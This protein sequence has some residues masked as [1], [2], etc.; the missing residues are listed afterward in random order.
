MN[1]TASAETLNLRAIG[2]AARQFEEYTLT[3]TA[4]PGVFW[5]KR[6]G[7]AY[8]TSLTHCSCEQ[9]RYRCSQVSGSECK[10]QSL[11]RIR[12]GAPSPFASG[13]W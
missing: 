5:V 11:V 1:S 13:L 2:R 10:H 4:Q 8:V 6:D 7:A 3:E 12:V 9:W